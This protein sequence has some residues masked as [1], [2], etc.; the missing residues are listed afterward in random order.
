LLLQLV[1]QFVDGEIQRRLARPGA[2]LLRSSVKLFLAG[3]RRRCC[4][5]AAGGGELWRPRPT[6]QTDRRPPPVRPDLY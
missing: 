2:T 5:A 1:M 4:A 6:S 3:V